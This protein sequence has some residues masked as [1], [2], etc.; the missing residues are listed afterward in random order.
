[1]FYA[2]EMSDFGMNNKICKICGKGIVQNFVSLSIG[3]IIQI[4]CTSIGMICSVLQLSRCNS[5]NKSTNDDSDV[6]LI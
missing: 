6:L 1:M 3:V 2:N 4:V 5:T